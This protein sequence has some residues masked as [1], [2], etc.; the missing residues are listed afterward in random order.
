[1]AD[2][3]WAGVANVIFIPTGEVVV[4]TDNLGA[5]RGWVA[6]THDKFILSVMA[7]TRD[8]WVASRIGEGRTSYSVLASR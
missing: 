4:S 3:A 6:A 7:A 5:S 8:S 2:A 1:M